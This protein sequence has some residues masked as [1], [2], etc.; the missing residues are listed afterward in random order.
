MAGKVLNLRFR[1]DQCGGKCFTVKTLEP[2][3]NDQISVEKKHGGNNKTARNTKYQVPS[4]VLV[5]SKKS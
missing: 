5:A 1:D 2:E 3:K 4:W